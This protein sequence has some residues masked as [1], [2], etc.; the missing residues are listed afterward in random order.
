MQRVEE[1][2][3]KLATKMIFPIVICFL[4]VFIVILVGPRPSRS[5][6]ASDRVGKRALSGSGGGATWG[7]APCQRQWSRVPDGLGTI[8]RLPTI[9]VQITPSRRPASTA[10]ARDSTSSLR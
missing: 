6:T 5:L 9:A 7:P 2:A 1:K 4:P 8:R 3:A 10:S